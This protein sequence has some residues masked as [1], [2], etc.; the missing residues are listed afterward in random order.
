MT[1]TEFFQQAE[2]LCQQ[3]LR[4]EITPDEASETISSLYFD[5]PESDQGFLASVIEANIW[6]DLREAVEALDPDEF[7]EEE[8]EQC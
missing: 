6:D 3:C 4:R 8:N 1:I 7:F 2:E 5:L